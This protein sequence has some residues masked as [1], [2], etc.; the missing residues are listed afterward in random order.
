MKIE[1]DISDLTEYIKG[2]EPQVVAFMDETAREALMRQKA[3]HAYEPKNTKRKDMLKTAT[4]IAEYKSGKR[5]R[6]YTNH[7]VNLESTLGYVITYDGKEKQRFV[8]NPENSPEAAAAASQLLDN[9]P[10]PITG[11]VIGDAMYYASFVSSKGYDVL[12]TAAS[13]LIKALNEGK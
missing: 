3:G 8:L 4:D 9:A 10:R 1:K 5:G 11:I 2:I 13:Y 7:T 12:D 6:P